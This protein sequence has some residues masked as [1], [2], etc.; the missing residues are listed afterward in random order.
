MLF[1]V[2]VRKLRR[3][4]E[5][6]SDLTN[7]AAPHWSARDPGLCTLVCRNEDS[8]TCEVLTAFGCAAAGRIT[9]GR[10]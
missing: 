3:S 5:P 7:Y 8:V 1:T 9:S 2:N 10:R 4:G 6:N